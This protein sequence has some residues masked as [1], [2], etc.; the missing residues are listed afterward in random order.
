MNVVI[1]T[2]LYV[3]ILNAMRLNV[4]ILNAIN[5]TT[6]FLKGEIDN[7]YYLFVLNILIQLNV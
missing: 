2:T 6:S 5:L 1:L 4:V 7:F 3:V